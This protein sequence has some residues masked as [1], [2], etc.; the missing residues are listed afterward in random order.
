[1]S[2]TPQLEYRPKGTEEGPGFNAPEFRPSLLI[3]EDHPTT[4]VALA[5]Q[6]R[7]EAARDAYTVY[8]RPEVVV[9]IAFDGIQASPHYPG[10]MALRFARVRR[11]RSDKSADAADT[12]DT[13]R[14]LYARQL[15]MPPAS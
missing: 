12:I 10:G 1:M 14:A 4:R 13:V 2:A 5:R 9:E 7:L 11:Y 3:V 6:G 8:L 15:R